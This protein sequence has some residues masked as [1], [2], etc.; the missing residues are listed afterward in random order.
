MDEHLWLICANYIIDRSNTGHTTKRFIDYFYG[1][2]E[3]VINEWKNKQNIEYPVYIT[4][5]ESYMIKIED[6]KND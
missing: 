1:T 3:D 5:C 4:T 6:K 2:K